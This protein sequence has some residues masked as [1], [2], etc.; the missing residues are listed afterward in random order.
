MYS[1]YTAKSAEMP[2]LPPNYSGVRFRRDTKR[3][4]NTAKKEEFSPPPEETPLQAVEKEVKKVGQEVKS[5]ET[6]VK[7]SLLSSIGDDD[8][9]L[10][11]L[12]IILA[13]ERD[14]NRDAVLL[15]LLLLCMR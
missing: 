15:L 3:T 8:L 2:V 1:R 9:F 4:A 10:A 13:A 6:A 7:K 14:D 12:I 11:A 5:G